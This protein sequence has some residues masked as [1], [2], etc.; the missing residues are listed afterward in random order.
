M[1]GQSTVA[2]RVIGGGFVPI[3]TATK[4][5]LDRSNA[6]QKTVGFQRNRAVRP[7]YGRHRIRC[8][9]L[10]LMPDVRIP[11][12]ADRWCRMRLRIDL[13]VRRLAW[14][15]VPSA[16]GN[17]RKIRRLNIVRHRPRSIGFALMA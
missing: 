11:Y 8:G 4:G 16:G 9:Q 14:Q 13:R 3:G 15:K 10:E 5:L 7:R 1:P 12:I 2:L 17:Y 6:H